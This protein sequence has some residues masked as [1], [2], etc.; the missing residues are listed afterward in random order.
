MVFLQNIVHF[1]HILAAD[2]LD[3]VA[4]VTGGVKASPTAP[5]GLAVQW[6]AACKRV[7]QTHRRRTESQDTDKLNQGAHTKSWIVMINE[8]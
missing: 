1:S 6:S 2:G 7:L 5:L 3:D 8:L 4:L